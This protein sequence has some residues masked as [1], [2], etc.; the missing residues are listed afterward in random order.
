MFF[1]KNFAAFCFSIIYSYTFDFVESPICEKTIR[2][3]E[4]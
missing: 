1:N 2:I 4:Q 3:F